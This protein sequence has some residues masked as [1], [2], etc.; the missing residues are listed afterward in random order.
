MKVLYY[1]WTPLNTPRVGGG[2]NVYL[3]NVL[4]YLIQHPDKHDIEPVFLSSG[5]MYDERLVPYI[6]KE[7]NI[8]GGGCPRTLT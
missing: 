7:Q 8:L 2:V 6:R 1:N 5:W 4:N 3:Q